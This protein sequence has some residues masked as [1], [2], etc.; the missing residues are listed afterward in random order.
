MLITRFINNE[1]TIVERL[2][3]EVIE[4][5]VCCRVES[6][7][8]LIDVI[9]GNDVWRYPFD[10]HSV[11]EVF[12]KGSLMGNLESTNTISE[13]IPIEHFLIDKCEQNTSRELGE[14]G[15]TFDQ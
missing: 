5:E 10:L 4:V 7:G 8:E 13:D 1:I 3:A 2:H 6:G 15:I 9:L 14:V 12:L 11:S